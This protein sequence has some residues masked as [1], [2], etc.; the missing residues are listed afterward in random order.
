VLADAGADFSVA[1]RDIAK[2]VA[3]PQPETQAKR[4]R[5]FAKA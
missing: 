1:M 3:N 4:R 5:F 2:S